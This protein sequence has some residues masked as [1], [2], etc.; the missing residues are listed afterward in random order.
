[1]DAYEFH[2]SYP[3]VSVTTIKDRSIVVDS[4]MAV[5]GMISIAPQL[6]AG[7][8]SDPAVIPRKPG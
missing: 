3:T 5:A 2:S 8:Y 6:S 7:R 4:L 1:M